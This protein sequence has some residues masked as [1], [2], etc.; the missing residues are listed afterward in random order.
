MPLLRKW[1]GNRKKEFLDL[2]VVEKNF[3]QKLKSK[4]TYHNNYL[5]K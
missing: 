2:N 4:V 1:G 3:P 5:T